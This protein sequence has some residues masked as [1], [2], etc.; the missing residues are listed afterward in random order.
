MPRDQV[1]GVMPGPCE[2]FRKEPDSLYETDSFHGCGFQVFYGG[3][4]PVVEYIELSPNCGFRA[5]YRGV[6]VFVTPAD[7]VVAH[8]V[9]DAPFDPDDPELGFGYIFPALDL[10][11][12]RPDL[13]ESPEDPEGREF[14]T[15]GVGIEGY[16]SL[17]QKLWTKAEPD[18]R[19]DTE[20]SNG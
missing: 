17:V 4:T 13:P 11:L 5:L 19:D 8:V 18:T 20:T 7:E 6:D 9:R 2:P 12:W 3:R 10:S 16:Y 14:S 1:R 15:I